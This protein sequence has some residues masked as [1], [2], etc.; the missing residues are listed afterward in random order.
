[1]LSVFAQF[2]CQLIVERVRSGMNRAK[3][4]GT[5]SGKAIGR[6]APVANRATEIRALAHSGLSMA[7]IARKLGLGYAGVHRVGPTL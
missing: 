5:R 3:K 7:A 4:H 6:P 2:E 1:M